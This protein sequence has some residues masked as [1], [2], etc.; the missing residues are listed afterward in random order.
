MHN[1]VSVILIILAAATV[2][3]A[4]HFF[5][6]WSLIEFFK[7]I[8]PGQSTALAVVIF[9]LAISFIL[10]SILAHWRENMFTRG[11]YFSSG[12][13]LGLVTNLLVTFFVAWVVIVIANFVGVNVNQAVVAVLAIC[14]SVLFTFCLTSR[15]Q[16]VPRSS[17]KSFSRVERRLS[18]T[19]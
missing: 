3:F 16:L 7:I 6:Y 10:A 4:S 12:I 9:L 5:V 15:R 19:V 1:I 18:P 17:F 11:L 14:F 2:L 13:W 8:D